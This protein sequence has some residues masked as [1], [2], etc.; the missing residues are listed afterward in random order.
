ML[1]EDNATPHDDQIGGVNHQ[2]DV[3]PNALREANILH[4]AFFG[5]PLPPPSSTTDIICKK[6]KVAL[7]KNERQCIGGH[8]ETIFGLSF[9]HDGRYMATASQDSTICI[10]EVATHKLVNTLSEGMDNKFECLRVAWMDM[11]D[12]NSMNDGGEQYLLASAGADGIVRLWSASSIEK[13]G[14]HLN[15]HFA[16][17]LD[18]Y[19]L[20]KHDESDSGGNKVPEQAN[21][22]E[23]EG[24]EEADRP[25][26]YTL[27]FIQSKART[28]L[29]TSTNGCI[30]L[31][32]IV[33]DTDSSETTENGTIIKR[34]KVVPYRSHHFCNV[35]DG[36]VF[37]GQRN[38]TNELYVFDASYCK[39]SQLL[40]VALSDGSCRVLSLH[41]GTNGNEPSCHE[42]CV[43][44]LPPDYFPGGNGGHLTALSWDQTGTRLATCIGSGRVVL[45]S[46]QIANENGINVLHASCISV[47]EGGELP[48]YVLSLPYLLYTYLILYLT[49]Y[50]WYVPFICKVMMMVDHYLV[51]SIVVEKM[52]SVHHD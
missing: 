45:W 17:S 39:S 9:S 49:R 22:E 32:N 23:E 26:I 20:T 40:G 30:H 2:S 13:G 37:G 21:N 50:H 29:M 44:R 33:E 43:L 47:L 34:R 14:K 1:V 18:H 28:I 19:K 51:Q 25:Q 7:P 31:H 38:P 15:W 48:T 52:R 42:Q 5:H 10:W 6:K 12:E 36:N 8:R 16:G 11:D 3:R 4:S 35:K 41:H 27:Q 24:E 46:L